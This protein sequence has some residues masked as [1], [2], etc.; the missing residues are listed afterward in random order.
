MKLL[1]FL[2]RNMRGLGPGI[3]VCLFAAATAVAAPPKDSTGAISGVV[4]N[5]AGT[6]QMGATIV[7]IG[8]SIHATPVTQ[9]LTDPHGVFAGERLAPGFYTVRVTLAGFLPTMERHVRVAAHLTTLVK[10][11]L[12]SVFS[13]LDRL[14]RQPDKQSG[15]D[16]WKWVLRTAPAMRPVLQWNEDGDNSIQDATLVQEVQQRRPRARLEFTSGGRHTGSVADLADS[17]GTAFAYDQK[18]GNIS[19]L[20]LA[21]Q[22]SYEHSAAA[23]I[24]TVWLPSGSL[25]SGPQT[26]LVLRQ[27]RLGPD[28]ITFRSLRMDQSGKVELG[29][30]IVFRYGAEFLLAGMRHSTSAIRP[31]GEV[32]ARLSENWLAELIFVAEPGVTTDRSG[33]DEER[34]AL[35]QS[36]M[37]QLDSYPVVLWRSGRP[38]LEGGWHKELALERKFSKHATVQVS[39]F[40][41]DSRHVAILGR[42]ASS[43]QDYFQDFFSDVFAYDGGSL[44]CWG[45]RLTFK[46]KISDALEISAVYAYAGALSLGDSVFTGDVRDALQTRYR[47]SLAGRISGRLPR[48]GTRMV[49]S[50]KF[51]DGPVLSHQDLFGEAQ[52]RIDPYL[53]VSIRQPLPHAILLGRVQALADLQNL[54]AQGYTAV[55][56]RDGKVSLL[57]ATRTFRGGLS[58]QF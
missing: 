36:A 14:R 50:Y 53:H 51:V 25:D 40:R 2:S 57:P 56:S 47:S 7:L 28:G 6:P 39:G 11:E 21:G 49:V 30:R 35:L 1:R 26:A 18:I 16:D 31:R 41:D 44:D 33:D 45:T 58:F 5:L 54:L 43:N 38:V 17:P 10:I 8:E 37:N 19:R 42:G 4:F 3:L 55:S 27:S 46:E 24:A 9:L 34:S 32:D 48:L 23:G 13:S 52:N 20:L 15:P 29:D 12:D 22:I